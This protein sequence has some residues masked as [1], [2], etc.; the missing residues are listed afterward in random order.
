MENTPTQ[1][2][3]A[4]VTAKADGCCPDP[5]TSG[6]VVGEAAVSLPA[7]ATLAVD[8]ESIPGDSDDGATD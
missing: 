1:A 5:V 7:L 2:G 8:A 3:C 6:R 4:E